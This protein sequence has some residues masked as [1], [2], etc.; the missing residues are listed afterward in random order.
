MA[1]AVR[2]GRPFRR[3][4][5]AAVHVS[6]SSWTSPRSIG[7]AALEPERVARRGQGNQVRVAERTAEIESR[8]RREVFAD[9]NSDRCFRFPMQRV[10]LRACSSGG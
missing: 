6:L 1:S 5:D 7:L 9:P 8:E 3:W 10:L 4:R 2:R